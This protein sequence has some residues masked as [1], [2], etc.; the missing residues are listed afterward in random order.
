MLAG[1]AWNPGAKLL[2]GKATMT[3]AHHRGQ[4]PKMYSG[5]QL[6]PDI[7]PKQKCFRLRRYNEGLFDEIFHEHVPNHRITIDSAIE[8]L[9]ALV[10]RHEEFSASHILRCYLNSRRGSPEALRILRIDV[11]YPEPGVIRRYCCSNNFNAWMDEVII[12][13]KFRK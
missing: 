8:M 13:A 9:K 4:L 12:P 6:C 2:H 7:D 5:F 1:H 10:L 11:E 3:S